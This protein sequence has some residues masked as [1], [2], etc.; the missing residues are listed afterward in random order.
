MRPF[1]A[2]SPLPLLAL[3]YA[4][5]GGHRVRRKIPHEEGKNTM[6][7]SL[8]PLVRTQMLLRDVNERIAEVAAPWNVDP[9]AFLCECSDPDC[10]GTVNLSLHQYEIIRSTTNLFVI[11]EGH[12]HPDVDRI[13][14]ARDGFTLVEKTKHIELVLS[15]QRTAPPRG[16]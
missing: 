4:A 7:T 5:L 8:E 9:P 15:W 3:V 10:V 14:Q 13:V 6:A 1:G 11:H 16:G 2:S 12:E